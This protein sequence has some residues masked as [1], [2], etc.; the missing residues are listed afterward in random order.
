MSSERFLDLESWA[1][2]EHFDLF[3]DYEKPFFNLCA[4]VDVTALRELCRGPDG[5]S[6]FLASLYLSLRA[7]NEVEPF[8]YRRRDGRVLV[9][10]VIHGGSTILRD[11]DT[12]GFGYFDY[13]RD[14]GRFHQRG[15]EILERVHGGP[16][17]LEP[18][19]GQ[20]DL[21]F[22]SVIPWVSFTSFSHARR[23]RGDD[24]I[25][26]IVF[27]KYFPEGERWKMPVSVEVHHALVDGLHVGRFFELY[28]R[29]LDE[30]RRALQG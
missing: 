21:I 6:F 10:E 23:Y 2:R 18:H 3:K 28:Q 13:D 20:D 14:F 27:G 4:P 8:R 25:P 11:D 24:S 22:Y 19:A 16:R 1:R 29:C 30:P 26:K 9:H 12:F 15:L 5:P 7:A 17:A